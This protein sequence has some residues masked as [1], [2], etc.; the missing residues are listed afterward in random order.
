MEE[1]GVTPALQEVP[2]LKQLPFV[3]PQ[4]H[5]TIVAYLAS[6]RARH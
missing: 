5:S 3:S 1:H 2:Q 4:N 6:L